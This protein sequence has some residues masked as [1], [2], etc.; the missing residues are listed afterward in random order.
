MNYDSDRH[1]DKYIVQTLNTISCPRPG[2]SGIARKYDSHCHSP[3][4]IKDAQFATLY[5]NITFGD[6]NR[7][8]SSNYTN[9]SY[10]RYSRDPAYLRF[11]TD[12]DN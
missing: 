7:T 4:S 12:N 6:D 2:Y 11:F 10:C 9:Q 1:N 3:R 8:S 5:D